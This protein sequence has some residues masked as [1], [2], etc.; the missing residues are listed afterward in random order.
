MSSPARNDYWTPFIGWTLLHARRSISWKLVAGAIIAPI[1]IWSGFSVT[2]LTGISQSLLTGVLPI[3]ALLFGSGV[4]REE[5]EQQTLTYS[6]TRPLP[7]QL[8]YA[9]RVLAAALPLAACLVPALVVVSLISD[10]R[11][12]L[13]L[14]CTAAGLGA[15]AY[16]ALFALVGQF[17]R[18]PLGI[19]LVFMAWE[20]LASK[21]PGVFGELTL[22]RHV[23]V[24]GGVPSKVLL[25]SD[26]ASAAPW[27]GAVV[28]TV[29]AILLI[30]G[31]AQI[32]ARRGFTLPR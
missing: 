3:L 21:V 9:S 15:F 4:I 32:M 6:L 27:V 2:E 29:V 12:S 20:S 31:G 7:R 14:L 18:R 8:L 23:G 25:T 1:I 26:S 28:L 24:L 13:V 16:V 19:G 5:I 22:T 30:L 10:G 17:A 11:L